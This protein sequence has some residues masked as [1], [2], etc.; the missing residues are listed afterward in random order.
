MV[1]TDTISV[2]SQGH[3][4][5]RDLTAEVQHSVEVS[6]LTS[7]LVTVFVGGST[8]AITTVEFEPGLVKDLKSL[9]ERIC[10]EDADYHHHATSGDDNGSAHVRAAM[11][12]P[13]VTIPF[14]QKTLALGDWQ[15]VVLVDF[16]T[17][18]RRRELVLLMIGE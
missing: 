8:A 13:S 18:P 14:M 12:G 2:N 11:V 4:D 7:G 10:P 1:K 17:R 3:T 16:D 6:G 5:V 9:F 15:Q